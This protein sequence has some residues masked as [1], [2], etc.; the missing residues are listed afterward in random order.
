MPIL[1]NFINNRIKI[2]TFGLGRNSGDELLKSIANRTNGDFF[3]VTYA[4]DLPDVIGNSDIDDLKDNPD[5]DLLWKMDSDGDS[6]PD[7]IE[8]YGLRPNGKPLGTDKDNP[9]SDGDGLSDGDEIKVDKDKFE[10]GY[11]NGNTQNGI[12]TPTDPTEIT[13]NAPYGQIKYKGEYY[14]MW[15]V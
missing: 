14:P 5:F 9:D 1:S 6:I 13:I 11:I 4:E 7:L 15:Q 10:E 12:N 2:Y 8:V 3:K